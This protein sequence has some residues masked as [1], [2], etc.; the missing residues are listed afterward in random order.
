MVLLTEACRVLACRTGPRLPGRRSLTASCYPVGR[1]DLG[2]F[3]VAG[4]SP[5]DEWPQYVL[6]ELT[7]L[8]SLRVVIA[9]DHP[10]YR[11]SLARWLRETGIEVVGEVATGEAAIRAAEETAPDVV[12]MDLKMPGLSG[13]EATRR[14]TTKAPASRVLVM[15][16]SAQEADVAD[17]L[18]AGASGYVLK[19]APVEEV[20][21]GIRAAAAGQPLISLRV[22]T[23][24]L[25]RLRDMAGAGVEPA[26]ERLSTREFEVLDLLADGKTD[27][28]IA[29]TLAISPRTV[30]KYISSI[31]TKLEVEG[32]IKAAVRSIRQPRK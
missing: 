7:E 2:R 20:I 31:L 29:E 18:L 17:A 5:N 15:S 4:R 24:L 11:A 32:R 13:L 22:A 14:L 26:G 27:A 3:A 16:V 21:A 23:V 25:R 30:R 1:P 10:F 9:D 6:R 19:D 12:I 28:E 8:G